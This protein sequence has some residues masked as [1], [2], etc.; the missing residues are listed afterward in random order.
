MYLSIIGD[1]KCDHL[2]KEVSA[3]SLAGHIPQWSKDLNSI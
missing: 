2:V 1:V 3:R